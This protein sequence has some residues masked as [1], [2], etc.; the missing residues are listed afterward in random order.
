MPCSFLYLLAQHP[1][2]LTVVQRGGKNQGDG[3]VAV[4]LSSV[5]YEEQC[6][7]AAEQQPGCLALQKPRS[8]SIHQD[9]CLQGRA[10]TAKQ[11]QGLQSGCLDGHQLCQLQWWYLTIL[12]SALLSALLLLVDSAAIHTCNTNT[13]NKGD[14][15]GLAGLANTS[16][17]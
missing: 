3:D 1:H 14:V 2:T 17:L 4:G 16:Y 11:V 5:H 7:G 10:D 8:F 15:G 13:S 6:P 9:L 12:V